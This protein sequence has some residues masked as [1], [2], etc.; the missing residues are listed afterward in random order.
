M[1]K[2]TFGGTVHLPLPLCEWYAYKAPAAQPTVKVEVTRLRYRLEVL[3]ESACIR[4]PVPQVPN[5]PG[6]FKAYGH[7]TELLEASVQLPQ[8]ITVLQRTDPFT[9]FA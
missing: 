3:R 6:A 8:P 7:P 5:A 9:R 4:R 1:P 2:E